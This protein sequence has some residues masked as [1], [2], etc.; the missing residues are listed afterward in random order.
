MYK[1]ILR[2]KDL[3]IKERKFNYKHSAFFATNH[4]TFIKIYETRISC[5]DNRC[6]NI[7]KLC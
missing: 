7:Q 6:K 4:D 2:Y 5:F 3:K 1:K